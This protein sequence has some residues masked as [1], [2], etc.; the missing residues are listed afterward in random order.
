MSGGKGRFKADDSKG[1][2]RS[3]EVTDSDLPVKRVYSW[4][5][6]PKDREESLGLPGDYPYTRGVY[7]TMYRGRLWT[8]RQYAGLG[9]AVES[10]ERYR[11]LL[12]Q[13]QTGLSVA[14]DLPSQMGYDS[15]NP[16]VEDEVGRVGVA[17]DTLGDMEVL[18]RDIPLDQISTNFTINSTAAMILAMYYSLAEKRGI[19]FGQVRGTVQNDMI[20]EFLARNTHIF[21]IEPSL[22]I[23]ADIIEFCR[24]E[25]PRFNPI[26]I[27]GYHI[28]EAGADAV[29]ELAL[30]LG[31]GIVYVHEVLERGI[32]VDEFASRLS[33]HLSSGPD[34]FEEIAKYR[35]ARKMWAEIM[36]RQFEC[37]DPKSELFRVFAGGN[38]I[39][40][41]ASEP[42]N[43]I[44]RA[45]LQCLVGVL[46]GA[47]AIHV[48]AYDEAFDIPT[49]ESAR[50]AL[51]TQQI[52]A[53][54][55]G[56]PRTADPLGGS[57]CVESLTNELENKAWA[58]MKD[59][60]RR[61]GLV[62]CI[63]TGYIQ[64]LIQD[65]AWQRER[66]I[67]SGQ[68]PVVGVNCFVSKKAE[69]VHLSAM[70]PQIL[71]RQKRA[72]EDV[73]KHRD[74]LAVQKALADLKRAA[75]SGENIMESIIGAVKTYAT[76]GEMAST[77]RE[78]YGEA[79]QRMV[80]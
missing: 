79:E 6:F 4:E 77:L 51:R 2:E 74:D 15:G 37:S 21:P 41:T 63:K 31:A 45:T 25:L 75:Q 5:D 3:L 71:K 65:R 36:R 48:P 29:Q 72:L 19:P 23:V 1:D 59:V 60:D 7:R 61:G 50:I 49:E 64:G 9:T 58:F 40:L 62:S 22:K 17:I 76:V 52:V 69:S 55:S 67:H 42:L 18:F 33:F 39:T 14:L 13:G 8:M 68:R 54:E 30:T 20:K 47:Q 46:G 27:S 56:I 26:S 38:G 70:D 53:F 80:V 12:S 43:N 73:K 66:Q 78:V 16:Q 11:F 57:Y 10:N 44:V 32:G 35:A 24:A 28:R 34:F